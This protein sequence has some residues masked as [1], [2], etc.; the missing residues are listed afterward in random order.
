MP[1]EKSSLHDE[2]VADRRRQHVIWYSAACVA[3][4]VVVGIMQLFFR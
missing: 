4:L 2:S 1:E 3:A